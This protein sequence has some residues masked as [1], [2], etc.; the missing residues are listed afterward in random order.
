MLAHSR[1]F[2]LMALASFPGVLYVAS[3]CGV[4]VVGVSATAERQA[5][6]VAALPTIAEVMRGREKREGLLVTYLDN[7]RGKV[8]LELPAPHGAR[9]DTPNVALRPGI[10]DRAIPAANGLATQSARELADNAPAGTVGRY[11]YLEGLVTGLGS[12]D[13]GLDRGQIGPTRVVDVRI[14]GGRCLIIEPNL[15][16]RAITDNPAEETAVRES[17]ASSILWAGDIAARDADGRTLIDFTSFVVRDAHD[18][19]ARLKQARQ[20][21]FVLDEKRSVLDPRNCLAFPDNLEFEAILTFASNEPGEFVRSVTPTP[22]AVTFVQRHSLV[23]LPDD[24]YEPRR[25]DPRAPSYPIAFDDY[26]APLDQPLTKRFITRHRLEKLDPSAP[27]GRVKE[28]IVYYVDRA[29]PEPVRTALLEGASWWAQAF[30][31]AGLEDAFRVELLPEDVHT[32]DI[33]YN[34]IQWVHRKTRGWSFGGTVT[35]PRTGEIIKGHVTLGSLRVRQDRLMFEG[36]L[37]SDKTGT[38]APDDPIE[39]SL[40]RIRQLSAHEV[41]HTL[42]FTHNFAASTYAGRA[43][44]M[45]YPAPLIKVSDDGTLDV[46]KAYAVGMGVWD[47]FAVRYAY[48]QFPPGTDEN[49]ALGSLIEQAIDRGMLFMSDD[50]AR[51]AGAAHPLANLWD[52]GSDPLDAL[53]QTMRVRE[54]A[55]ERFGE[56]NIAKGRPVAELQ[57]VFAT[58]YLHHRYQLEAA[59]KTIGGIDYA[60]R[61]RGDHQPHVTPVDADR[62]RRALDVVLTCLTPEFLDVPDGT[63]ELLAPRPFGYDENREMFEGASDPMFDPIAAAAT[64]ADLVVSGIL[65]KERCTR[66]VDQERRNAVR[67]GLAATLDKLTNQAFFG[68]PVGLRR[69]AIKQGVQQVVV[70]RMMELAADE[71]ASPLVRAQVERFLAYVAGVYEIWSQRNEPDAPYAALMSRQIK[72]F[73]ERPHQPTPPP[74]GPHDAPPGSPIGQDGYDPGPC[75][76]Q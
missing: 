28:P 42:G 22:Q 50:D 25:F 61:L 75:S 74:S 33:R 2:V 9:G 4:A 49:D 41:G 29:A 21:T 69:A 37:G 76:H 73:I 10:P 57:E 47:I 58:V 60:Y 56:R 12:N 36:L 55:M 7:E 70:S 64:A 11:A 68:P 52:N 15:Q 6:R 24:G 13:V 17:F 38:G 16:A 67:L 34:V 35:D 32:L 27:R 62:Q 14:V 46:S 59:I 20:G 30:E 31:A 18:V 72:R 66:L 71:S 23:R 40:A 44:V 45:D 3:G 53:E 5:G 26:A 54:I 51:P 65:N 43:S 63:L 8:W 1:M 19:A 48:S 39:L